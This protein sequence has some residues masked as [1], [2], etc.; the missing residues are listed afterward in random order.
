MSRY[1]NKKNNY[2]FSSPSND[3]LTPFWE[4]FIPRHGF[5]SSWSKP[6]ECI[7]VQIPTT[8]LWRGEDVSGGKE[9]SQKGQKS[10]QA[11]RNDV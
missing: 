4:V 10:S 2:R 11:V 6:Q 7:S 8:G 3:L 9:R 5:S 1:L